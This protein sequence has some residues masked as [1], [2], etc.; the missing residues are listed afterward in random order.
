[1]LNWL[2]KLFGRP[3]QEAMTPRRFT[4][5][6]RVVHDEKTIVVDDREGG[7][8]RLAWSDVRSVTVLTTAAGPFEIDLFWV[9]ADQ[10]GRHTLSVPMGAEGEHALLQAMQARF[11]G[12]DNMAVVEA[13]SSAGPG[14]FQVWPAA[15]VA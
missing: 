3:R 7:I 15:E 9:L 11:A 12:F 6:V 8:S 2:S 1:M 14:V 10:D 5:A 4:S 13:M